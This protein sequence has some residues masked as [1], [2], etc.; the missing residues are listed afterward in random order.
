MKSLVV[1]SSQTGNTKKL[2]EAVYEAL[3]A[4]KEICPTDKALEIL[5]G[6]DLIAVGFWLMGG[7]PDPKSQE[8]LQKTND[9]K[10]FLFASH[11][12]AKDSAHAKKAMEVATEMTSSTKVVGTFSCQGEVNPK[13]LEKAGANPE[14][15]PWLADAPSAKGHPDQTDLKELMDLVDETCQG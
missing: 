4:P 8:F 3:P 9:K 5:D 13:V 12:A 2:A 11:G 1:Y 6:F 10:V 14:P 7:K 15:P